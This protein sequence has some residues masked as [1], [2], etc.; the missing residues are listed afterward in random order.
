MDKAV[1]KLKPADFATDQEV[2]WCPGCGDFAVLK[3]MRR[4]LAEIGATR[5]QTVFVFGSMEKVGWGI[6]VLSGFL[7]S[8]YQG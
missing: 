5:E 1:A 3:A 8:N 2:R 4:T 7:P 6:P